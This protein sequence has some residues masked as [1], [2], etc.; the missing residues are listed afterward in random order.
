MNTRFVRRPRRPT[1][2]AA[3]ALCAGL[4][5][6][7]AAAG[8][9]A[10]STTLEI[11][12]TL[13]GTLAAGDTARY[14]IEANENDFVLGEV[15]Q[16]SVDVTARVLDPDGTQVRRLPNGRDHPKLSR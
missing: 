7:F 15:D 5:A 8:V 9:A 4:L 10:Q 2:T 13:S 14:T 11:G 3:S 16:I 12:R 6:L 1:G